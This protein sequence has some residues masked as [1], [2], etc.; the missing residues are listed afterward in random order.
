MKGINHV[1]WIWVVPLFC[2][3][4]VV[5]RRVHNVVRIMCN[6]NSIKNNCFVTDQ[7]RFDN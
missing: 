7:S 4:A 3:Y 6:L 5:D 2:Y 1:I